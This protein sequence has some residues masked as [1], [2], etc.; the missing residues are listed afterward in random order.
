MGDSGETD[1]IP[2]EGWFSAIIWVVSKSA[3]GRVTPS[4]SCARRHVVTPC[5]RL[6]LDCRDGGGPHPDLDLFWISALCYL[7]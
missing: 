3:G 4:L 5:P 1:V 7:L 6:V 2:G